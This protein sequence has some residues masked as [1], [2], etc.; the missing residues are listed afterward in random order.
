[1]SKT[2]YGKAPYLAKYDTAVRTSKQII[3][4]DGFYNVPSQGIKNI[5]KDPRAQKLVTD[6]KKQ[7]EAIQKEPLSA[8]EKERKIAHYAVKQT[9]DIFGD[10]DKLNYEIGK[11]KYKSDSEK[12]V[13]QKTWQP[14][15]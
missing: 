1:M 6:V 14:K 10:Y 13:S 9:H 2:Y 8:I 3:N 5:S 7:W 4:E 12:T 11:Q 15:P